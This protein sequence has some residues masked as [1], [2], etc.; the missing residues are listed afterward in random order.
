MKENYTHIAIVLDRSGSMAVT[1]M[2]TIGGFNTFLKSQK[3]A[4]GEATLTLAQFDNQYEVVYNFEP[5]QAVED[6]TPLTFVPRGGTA[7]HDAMGRT[8]IEI[9][10]QISNLL[11]EDK[12][13]KVLFVVIT[14]GE[15]NASQEFRSEQIKDMLTHQQ[16]KCN[17]KFLFLGA[18]QDA[19]LTGGKLGFHAGAT[20]AYACSSAGIGASFDSLAVNTTMYRSKSNASATVEFT[21]KDRKAQEDAKI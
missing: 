8:I 20:M 3:E 6:L 11:E 17:W 4:P 19:A 13:S 14:D 1:A 21:D 9:G 7:L 12:P 5:I 16:D 15:E 18:N 10:N 2:D